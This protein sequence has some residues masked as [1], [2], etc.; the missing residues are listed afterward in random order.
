[1]LKSNPDEKT[2]YS[3]EDSATG[4]FP[5]HERSDTI[6]HPDAQLHAQELQ[7]DR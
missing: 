4:S 5:P 6:K 2:H 7:Q 1:M 3:S